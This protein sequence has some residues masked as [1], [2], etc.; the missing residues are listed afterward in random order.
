MESTIPADPATGPRLGS[1][2]G[3]VAL[4]RDDGSVICERC[5]VADRML[6]RMKGLLGRRSLPAGEGLLIRPAPSIHTFFMRFAIDAVFLGRDGNVLKVADN[7]TPWRARSCR[8]ARAVLELAAGEAKRR[9]ISRGDLL[10]VTE[11]KA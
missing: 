2:R 1:A 9:G 8:G 10:A 3:V 5:V 6:P 7:V 11:A 4:A